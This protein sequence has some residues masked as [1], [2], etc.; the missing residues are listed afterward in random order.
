L[1]LDPQAAPDAEA[2]L[3][4]VAK[5]VIAHD[6]AGRLIFANELAAR[7]M[8]YPS[9]RALMASSVS[10]LTS[11]FEIADEEGRPL[12]KEINP[13]GRALSGQES[14]EALVR[15]RPRAT[16]EWRWWEVRS[17]A[18]FD[19]EGRVRFAVSVLYD[20]TERKEAA[21]AQRLL[22]EAG[23]VLTSSL[24][25]QVT[26]NEVARLGIPLLADCCAVHLLEPSGRLTMIALAHRDRDKEAGA[27]EM[28]RRYPPNPGDPSGVAAVARTGRPEI[29]GRI[30]D[31]GL[32]NT[33]LD[34]ERRTLLQTT[35]MRSAMLV[36]LLA[37][38]R[39]LG[40]LTF[41]FTDSGR[42]A[43]TARLAVAE[44]LANRAALAIDNARLYLQAQEAVLARDDLLAI[45]SHDLKNPLSAI[46]VS[47]AALREI[48]PDDERFER[49]SYR[50]ELI[51]RAAYRMNH[52]IAQLLDSASIEAGRLPVERKPQSVAAL[53]VEAVEAMESL[54]RQKS[55]RLAA[56]VAA[57]GA[58]VALCDRE[59]VLQVL[60]N[61][62]GNAIKFTAEEGQITVAAELLEGEAQLAVI[63][64]GAGI[65]ED[66]RAHLFE[67]YW[68]GD[69]AKRLGT[70]LGLYIAKGIV[71]AHGGRIWVESQPGRGSTFYFTLPLAR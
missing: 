19:A 56:R 58:G 27:W 57:G 13:G 32:S 38:G 43:T 35:A 16:N 3:A 8:G 26:L 17:R 42:H 39:T 50:A 69:R 28:S 10:E 55:L 23:R 44:E 46:L 37:R 53:V 47:S 14:A 4:S 18:V 48:V 12:T 51:Q 30:D 66:Q 67:R 71:E 41:A 40:V 7:L 21:D 11:R 65:P 24:D 68:Q 33:A 25:Y 49:V 36:P 63:D 45:V 9:A 31:E 60:S 64:T 22:V 1:T 5:A 59:R 34:A 52:L 6:R 61:L 70:G 15:V 54:A 29:F 20:V 2:I 62:I